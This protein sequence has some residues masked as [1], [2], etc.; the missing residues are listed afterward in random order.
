M[1]K[2][3]FVLALGAFAACGNGTSTDA[4]KDSTVKAIDSTAGAAKDSL[5]KKVDSL[6]AGVDSTV[7]AAK[8][9]LKK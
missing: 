1:K 4:A 9:S 3:L 8:D 2:L 6:K 7:K 5:N